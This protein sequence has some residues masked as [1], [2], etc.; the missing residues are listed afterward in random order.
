M[1]DFNTPMDNP[2]HPSTKKFMDTLYSF[3]LIQHV[4]QPTHKSGHTLDLLITRQSE[5]L[6]DVSV[7]DTLISD[8][9][10]VLFKLKS[11]RPPL[12][13]K[14]LEYGKL[15][16][17]DM[18]K[19]AQDIRSSSLF[20]STYTDVNQFAE[21]YNQVLSELLEK[22]AP[23][24]QKTITL[25]PSAPWYTDEI[26]EAKQERRQADRKWR[27]SGLTVHKQ[28]FQE[29]KIK[30]DTMISNSKV[31]YYNQKINESSDSQRSFFNCID[32]LLNRKQSSKL[33]DHNSDK[34]LAHQMSQFF[35]D[36]VST[37]RSKLEA[38]K[39]N[40]CLHTAPEQSLVCEASYL[41]DFQQATEEEVRKIIMLSATKSSIL[42]PIPTQ[43]LKG[44]IDAILPVITRLINLS[45][46]TAT[47]QD[48]FRVAAVRPLLKKSD[49]DHNTLK[50]FRPVSNLPF[51]S[52]VLE[53][54]VAKRLQHHRD[55]NQLNEKMQS[56]YRR[57]HSTETALLRIQ[58]DLLGAVDSK[59]C[60]YLVL[61]DLS[62]AFDTV[63]H[64]ILLQRLADQFG[65]RDSCL[66]WIQSYLHN[67]KQFVV[68]NGATS[69]KHTLDC[70]VP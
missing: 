49:L 53:K 37:I 70:D 41:V 21:A 45:L 57:H 4:R 68:I 14:E 67:R 60:T 50:N 3:G 38:F 23:L 44:C 33:P 52:K 61:L 34:T 55:S 46:D 42:D 18:D 24:Q 48:C 6:S 17:I 29:L 13:K 35:V 7:Y 43:I 40:H 26:K 30:V 22:H 25:H 11:K 9:A 66:N 59:K 65:I 27:Q 10:A 58:N 47:F 64:P 12:P 16:R 1:G 36:K 28:I 8:H 39:L 63:D 5:A 32:E 69:D 15:K 19:F 56:A 2:S 51:V 62:A 20:S 54:V 31:D